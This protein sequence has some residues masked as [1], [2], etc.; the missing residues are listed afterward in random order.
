MIVEGLEIPTLLL[1][2]IETGVWPSHPDSLV[3]QNTRSLI[4]EDCNRRLRR[5]CLYPPPFKTLAQAGAGKGPDDFYTRYGAIHELVT[6]TAIE[7]AD[8]GIGEDSP[9]L[10]DFRRGPSNPSVIYLGWSD[11][12][13]A[14]TWIEMAPDFESFAEMLGLRRP[15]AE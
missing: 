8:F 7:I 1:T 13:R 5:I 3:E 11:G 15:T 4:P 14:N 6:E 2:L 9:I 10:L 12:E